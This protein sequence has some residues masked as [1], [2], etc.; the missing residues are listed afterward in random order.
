MN[1]ES[2]MAAGMLSDDNPLLFDGAPVLLDDPAIAPP[3]RPAYGAM[4]RIMRRR[5]ECNKPCSG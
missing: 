4:V 5:S 1:F 2:R 3:R